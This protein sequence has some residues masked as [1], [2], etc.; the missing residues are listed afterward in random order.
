MKKLLVVS[1]SVR[2]GSAGSNVALQVATLAKKSFEVT[3]VN[4]IDLPLPLLDSPLIPSDE[5]FKPDNENVKKWTA[6]V[7]ESDAVIFVTPEYNRSYSAV[8]KN[9]IDWVY[10]PWEAKPVGLVGYSWKGAPNAIRHLKEVLD[11]VKTSVVATDAQ[12]VFMN[13]I[14]PSG[15]SISDTAAEKL[16]KVLESLQTATS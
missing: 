2:R 16:G 5:N 14:D 15:K 11:H 9:A 1:G 6:L 12:L 4:F 8:I 3:A 10:Q 7:A 13:D